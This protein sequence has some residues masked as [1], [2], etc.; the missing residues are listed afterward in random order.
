MDYI[1]IINGLVNF[2]LVAVIVLVVI[3]L[4][5]SV[6]CKKFK[7]NKKNIEL[8]GLLMSLDSLSLVS[9]ASLTICYLFLVWCTISFEGLNI[10][11]ISFIVILVVI[12]DVVIDRFNRLPVSL[13]LTVVDCVAIQVIYVIYKYLVETE[14][15][16]FLLVILILVIIFVFLYYT[17]NFFRQINNIVVKNKYLKDKQY[18]I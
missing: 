13:L 11:Y 6:F 8:Y 7:F 17:Y 2:S 15:S 4:V 9:I 3:A 12:G 14:F 16:Y 10:I 5:F 1:E 18:K